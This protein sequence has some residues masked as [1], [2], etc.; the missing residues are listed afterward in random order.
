MGWIK[1]QKGRDDIRRIHPSRD[2]I[3]H[4]LNTRTVHTG[5]TDC[6]SDSLTLI[7]LSPRV[8]SLE[9][10]DVWSLNHVLERDLSFSSVSLSV[11]LLTSNGTNARSSSLD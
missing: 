3:N 2:K 4:T 5:E 6:F 8:V 9:K 7:C 1:Y 10:T 11:V